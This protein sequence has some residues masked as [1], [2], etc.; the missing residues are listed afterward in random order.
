MQ[1]SSLKRAAL[2]VFSGVEK[3]NLCFGLV[4][5]CQVEQIW[6]GH[7]TGE[8]GFGILREELGET[9]RQ[10]ATGDTLGGS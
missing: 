4:R 1:K 5:D 10:F 2:L 7:C 3:A 8:E 6:T 9:V